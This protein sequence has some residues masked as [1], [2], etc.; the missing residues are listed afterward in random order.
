M[1]I[2]KII[3][4]IE[5]SVARDFA[6]IWRICKKIRLLIDE[7]AEVFNSEE[8]VK[9]M[10]IMQTVSFTAFLL[11][12]ALMHFRINSFSFV[13]LSG[14]VFF[15]FSIVQ[16][17]SLC[18]RSV[19]LSLLLLMSLHALFL[20]SICTEWLDGLKLYIWGIYLL[21]IWVYSFLADTKVSKLSNQIVSAIIGLAFTCF[22][23]GFVFFDY[24]EKPEMVDSSNRFLLYLLSMVFVSLSF[25]IISDVREYWEEKY[26]RNDK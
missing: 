20:V 5:N 17:L 7:K 10:S 22:S 8:Y 19:F 16:V 15:I 2:S 23:F 18:F 3:S 24:Y 4:K 11:F 25:S 13:I 12:V 1:C 21:L 9:F 6:Y 14:F 26:G